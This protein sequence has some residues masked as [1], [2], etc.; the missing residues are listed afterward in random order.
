MYKEDQLKDFIESKI[1]EYHENILIKLGKLKLK[2][3]LKKKNPYLFKNKG[4]TS[5]AELI[6]HILSA[7]LSSSEESLFGSVLEQIAIFICGKKYGGTKS[8]TTGIDLEF[9][10]EGTKYLV[11]IKSGKNWSNA[12]S[13]AKL[14]DNFRTA[15]KTIGTN[16]NKQRVVAVIGVCYGTDNIA[17]KG[18]Y[19]HL[20][21]QRFWQ[22]ISGEDELFKKIIVPLNQTQQQKDKFDIEYTKL[23]QTFITQ[24]Q[25]DYCNDLDEI[26]WDKLL[27]FNASAEPGWQRMHI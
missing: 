19:L 10:A 24:F 3:V 23:E 18:D 4:I 27:D 21:G 8:A 2:A 1:N 22:F 11:A 9:T 26:E 20:C 7:S 5:S 16:T 12:A 13:K 14:L 25:N 17:E 15:K 6:K